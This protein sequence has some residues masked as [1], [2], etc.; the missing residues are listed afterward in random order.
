MKMSISV[1]QMVLILKRVEKLL[2]GNTKNILGIKYVNFDYDN[3]GKDI[4]RVVFRCWGEEK[5]FTNTNRDIRKQ[6]D[7]YEEI[8][9]W[10]DSEVK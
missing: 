7:L 8:N 5:I 1:N 4:W 9:E 2:I 10:L 6:R 3:R